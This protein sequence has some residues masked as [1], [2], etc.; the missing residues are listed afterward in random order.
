MNGSKVNLRGLLI[1]HTDSL[2]SNPTGKVGFHHLESIWLGSTTAFLTQDQ[3]QKTSLAHRPR[4]CEG[5]SGWRRHLHPLGL[6]AVNDGRRKPGKHPSHPAKAAATLLRKE[7][8][9]YFLQRQSVGKESATSF[10]CILGIVSL[11]PGL[12]GDKTATPSLISCLESAMDDSGTHCGCG[13][14]E[15]PGLL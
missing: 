11:H 9:L 10:L 13:F 3:T 6:R 12:M 8:V 1:Y 4:Q 7:H 5:R 2:G 15:H 14:H